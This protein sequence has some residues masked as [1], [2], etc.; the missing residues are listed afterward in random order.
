MIALVTIPPPTD[1]FWN[2]SLGNILTIVTLLVAFAAAHR[3]N[4]KRIEKDAADRQEM[5]TKVDLI[6]EW[7][8]RHVIGGRSG[9]GGYTP[10]KRSGD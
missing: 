6:F 9:D 1:P 5:K 8:Q 4:T 3:S 7:F 2:M 10:G